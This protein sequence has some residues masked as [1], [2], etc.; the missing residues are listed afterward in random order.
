MT[1]KHLNGVFVFDRDGKAV[2]AYKAP[3][4]SYLVVVNAD[5]EVV[6]TGV[7]ADQDVAAAIAKAFPM[8]HAMQ[9]G[10]R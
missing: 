8:S 7:G 5:G 6:Y 4:T 1:A 9:P 10:G 2:A 3:H